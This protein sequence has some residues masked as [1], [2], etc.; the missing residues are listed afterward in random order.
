MGKIF[1]A[2][3][4][5]ASTD[6]QKNIMIQLLQIDKVVF[7]CVND[8][9]ELIQVYPFCR[10]RRGPDCMVVGFT[11]ISAISAHHQ[12]KTVL[13]RKSFHHIMI[14]LLQ[15]DKKQCC[16]ENLFTIS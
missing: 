3:H 16:S 10:G 2:Y 8:M 4:D 1:T 6:R 14:Q 7:H 9:F 13:F 11:T 5:T 15:I 12:Q